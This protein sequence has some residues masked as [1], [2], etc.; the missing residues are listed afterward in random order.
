MPREQVNTTIGSGNLQLSSGQSGVVTQQAHTFDPRDS[1]WGQLAS[2]LSTI[3]PEIKRY[4]LEKKAL[5]DEE[6]KERAKAFGVNLAAQKDTMN[7]LQAGNQALLA[8]GLPKAV[9]PLAERAYRLGFA[10]NQGNGYGNELSARMNEATSSRDTR[11]DPE[12]IISEIYEKYSGQY[13][14]DPEAFAEFNLIKSQY[15]NQFR[16][17]VTNANL[18]SDE[19]EGTINIVNNLTNTFK[20]AHGALFSDEGDTDNVKY[21]ALQAGY[22]DLSDTHLHG[23]KAKVFID[24]VVGPTV[25][26]LISNG[27]LEKA[28]EYLDV[29]GAVQANPDGVTLDHG[30]KSKDA[31][32][33]LQ[34]KINSKQVQMEKQADIESSRLKRQKSDNVRLTLEE[35]LLGDNSQVYLDADIDTITSYAKQKF[36]DDRVSQGYYIDGLLTKQTKRGVDTPP[37]LV[38]D[39]QQKLANGVM[40]IEDAI[41]DPKLGDKEAAKL[42]QWN[43]EYLKAADS[44]T[45]E[46]FPIKAVTQYIG[47][48]S[49]TF[50]TDG[51]TL[52]YK[53]EG[54]D[55]FSRMSPTNQD[56]VMKTLKTWTDQEIKSFAREDLSQT[57][58]LNKTKANIAVQ[59]LEMKDRIKEKF[60]SL[61]QESYVKDQKEQRR[62]QLRKETVDE[63]YSAKI[64][65]AKEVLSQFNL[66]P[67]NLPGLAH[68]KAFE[69]Q[70]KQQLQNLTEGQEEALD[71]YA[72][73]KQVIG[74]LPEEVLEGMTETG[75]LFPVKDINYKETPV[76]TSL[77]ELNK[78]YNKGNYEE[79]GLFDVL[80][81]KLN[82]E[83]HDV[84]YKAQRA[85]LI[86]K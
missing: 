60:D 5:S 74:Y 72:R 34:D 20:E 64:E 36:P 11:V 63:I 59:Q 33:K 10:K 45:N 1:G 27:E 47:R 51:Y 35:D 57:G 19:E 80:G 82:A 46:T 79:G 84:F 4:G 68:V 61:V 24:D 40:D 81:T 15:D 12:S 8:S 41:L 67:S 25:T 18:K 13:A 26:E 58:D 56:G 42:K 39:L 66:V 29:A 77:E 38:Y 69:E 31:L 17:S 76:F 14:D 44:L 30:G 22:R 16:T 50:A 7:N 43:N 85:L 53:G 83:K 70:Q 3:N 55:N 52:E 86:N 65:R 78:E 32:V 71:T 28:R 75:V 48:R 49:D 23:D 54:A 9:I 21:N 73:A 37:G 2:A 62:W 6:D